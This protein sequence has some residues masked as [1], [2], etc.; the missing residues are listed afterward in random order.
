M[1]ELRVLIVAGDL[2]AR[3]GLAALLADQ[4]HVVGQV[5]AD[6]TLA[7]TL[8]VYQPDVLLWDLGWE[9]DINGFMS[10]LDN[11][12]LVE[13]VLVLL[14]DETHAQAVTTLIG[15]NGG[16]LPRNISAERLVTATS[17]V[18]QGLMVLDPTLAEAV[19]PGGTPAVDPPV[20]DLTP[21]EI[22]VLRL[23]AEGLPNKTIARRLGIS[24]H[25]VKF[26]VNAIMTKLDAQSR[27]GAVVKAM[28]LGL[29]VL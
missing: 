29:L 13:P 10:L 1:S 5:D 22:E 3:T 4:V 6:T 24:D 7:D 23:L 8:D 20:E 11:L 26:H 16:L 27:T 19:L 2:L 9:P 25:T 18:A 17:A 28:R 14:P 12:E 15:P 21:R